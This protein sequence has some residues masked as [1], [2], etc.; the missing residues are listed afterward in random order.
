MPDDDPFRIVEIRN[1]HDSD[2]PVILVSAAAQEILAGDLETPVVSALAHRVRQ[3][4]RSADPN[5]PRTVTD[6]DL[7]DGRRLTGV[8]GGRTII[9]GAPRHTEDGC[10]PAPTALDARGLPAEDRPAAC[11]AQRVDLRARFRAL[12]LAADPGDLA[13]EAALRNEAITLVILQRMASELLSSTGASHL[14]D[15]Y[16]DDPRMLAALGGPT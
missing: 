11:P 8:S 9:L 5:G 12:Y 3:A 2:A 16:V 4:A 10:R 6:L 7:E 14:T 15:V 1:P 13:G